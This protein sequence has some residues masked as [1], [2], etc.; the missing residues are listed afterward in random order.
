MSVKIGSVSCCLPEKVEELDDLQ[1]IADANSARSFLVFLRWHLL[2]LE[3][4]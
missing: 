2:E 4:N 1:Y 3:A